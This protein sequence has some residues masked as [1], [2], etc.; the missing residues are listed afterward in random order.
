[1]VMV[2]VNNDR[3]RVRADHAPSKRFGQQ[4]RGQ[5]VVGCAIGQHTSCQQHDPIG[6]ACL[7]Q[8]VGGEDHRRTACR[9]GGDHLKDDFLTGQVK[10][11]NGFIE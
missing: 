7:A 4:C 1:M 9:L 6:A 10:A 5:H 11:S 3:R 8:M 2:L